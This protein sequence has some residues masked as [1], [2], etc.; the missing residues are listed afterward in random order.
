MALHMDWAIEG[1]IGSEQRLDV[2]YL[3]PQIDMATRYCCMCEDYNVPLIISENMYNL[4]TAKVKGLI[5]KMDI[6]TTNEIKAPVGVYTFEISEEPLLAPEDDERKLGDIILLEEYSTASIEIYKAKSEDYMFTIDADIA[7]A[8]PIINEIHDT[9]KEGLANYISGDWE[10][11]VG[12][13]EQCINSI[14]SDGPSNTL[15]EFTELYGYKAPFAWK[16]YRNLDNPLEGDAGEAEDEPAEEQKKEEAAEPLK[17]AD[18]QP[19]TEA[20][21]NVGR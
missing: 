17:P 6:I 7:Q 2:T 5:R 9:Y 18:T 1:G 13:F 3:S 14:S 15:L 10:K 16:G 11:A 4:F 21:S 12:F 19:V 20:S 8:F